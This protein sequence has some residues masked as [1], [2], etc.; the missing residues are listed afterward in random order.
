MSFDP[1]AIVGRGCVLPGARS[2]AAL[3]SLVAEG[4]DAIGPVPPGR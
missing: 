2:P 4:R 1:I 3:W